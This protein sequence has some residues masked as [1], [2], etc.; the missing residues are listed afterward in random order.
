MI[1][2]FVSLFVKTFHDATS[3]NE[4]ATALLPLTRQSAQLARWGTH[5]DDEKEYK[6]QI[7]QLSSDTSSINRERRQIK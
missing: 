4:P 6:Q 2:L 3:P 5:A 7:N 1:N